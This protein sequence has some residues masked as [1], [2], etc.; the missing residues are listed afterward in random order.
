MKIPRR[1]PFAVPLL[2]LTGAGTVYA[3]EIPEKVTIGD[4]PPE[5]SADR[6]YSE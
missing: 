5:P 6:G 3:L 2:K 1:S 4:R